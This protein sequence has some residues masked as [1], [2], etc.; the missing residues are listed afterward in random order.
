MKSLFVLRQGRGRVVR[1]A[2]NRNGELVGQ[3]K[4]MALM[5]TKP[6]GRID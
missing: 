6:A 4:R 5:L 2:A 3:R 1:R